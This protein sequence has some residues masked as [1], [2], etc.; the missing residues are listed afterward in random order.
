MSP[1]QLAAFRR[2]AADGRLRR[3]QRPLLAR[4]DPVRAAHRPA[5]VPGPHRV[6]GRQSDRHDRRPATGRRRGSAAST[7]TVT[8]AAESI[9]R[10]C[11]EPDP[12]RR[13][14]SARDLREDIERHLA[15]RPLRH[16]PDPSVRERA[17]KLVRRHPRLYAAAKAAVV[18]AALIAGAAW[19]VV[20]DREHK[21]LRA[22]QAFTRLETEWNAEHALLNSVLNS[23]SRSDQRRAADLAYSALAPYGVDNPHWQ[24]GPLVTA[25]PPA[26]RERLAVRV[27]GL[28][29]AGAEAEMR[30]A[31]DEP[32]DG[33]QDA[34]SRPPPD[35]TGSGLCRPGRGRSGR[36][37]HLATETRPGR[38]PGTDGTGRPDPAPH[39]RRLLL[40]RPGAGP[41][42]RMAG[43]IPHLQEAVRLEPKHF[44]ALNNLGNCYFDL[45]QRRDA[46]ACYGACVGL[47][48]DRDPLTSYF[49][50]YHRGLA[51]R[52][53]GAYA[54]AR[55]DLETAISL[56]PGLPADLLQRER[57]KVYRLLAETLMEV[58]RASHR[59]ADLAEAEKVLDTA[60]GFGD[61]LHVLHFRRGQVF[62]LRNDKLAGRPG[63][64]RG[65]CPS[66]RRRMGLDLPRPGLPGKGRCRRGTGGVRPGAGVQ[67]DLLP[68]AA[69]QGQRSEREARQGRRVA[70]RAGPARRPLSRLRQG[71]HRPGRAAGPSRPAARCPRRTRPPRWRW[72]GP[73]KPITWPPTSTR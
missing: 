2:S 23:Y 5:A 9:V 58:A 31:G 32:G 18:S 40:S 71:P 59:P 70:D 3:P 6:A 16:A 36:M 21:R 66:A 69:K 15:H 57:P 1:E 53:L 60:I 4:P 41:P 30:W 35:R 24:D 43:A 28:L 61:G 17:R 73:A 27:A 45:G 20:H 65:A 47:A 72:T 38:L 10:K 33:R 52:S 67:P 49:A 64:G 62:K 55:T 68:G 44:W 63:L 11:L 48:A 54:E 50:H 22:E 46:L 56:L 34:L 51:Y 14:Q 19:L 7:R 12:G 26:Q 42:E 39:G 13:Y 37:G 8:P 29:F 25:L